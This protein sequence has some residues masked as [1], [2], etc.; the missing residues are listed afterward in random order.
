VGVARTVL[1]RV[2]K[3]LKARWGPA[4]QSDTDFIESAFREILGRNAD[5]D[6]LTHYRRVLRDGLGRTAVLLDIM[7][8]DESL[9]KLQKTKP[10]GTGSALPDIRSLRPDRYRNA[11]DRTNQ[12]TI[13]VFDASSAA[14]FDWLEDAI[15]KYGYYEQ[16]GVWTLGIDADKVIVA[17]MIASLAPRRALELG[18]AAGAVLECLDDLG[19]AAEGVEISAMARAKAS[20]RVR[21]RIHDGDLLALDLPSSFDVLFGLDVFEHLNPNRLDAYVARLAAIALDGAFVFCNIP[22]FGHDPQFGT[23]FPLYLDGWERDTAAGRPFATLHVDELGYP[24]HGH[25]TWADARWWVSCFE[26]AGLQREIEIERALHA[27]YDR[28][29]EKRAPARKAY[30]VFAKSPSSDR[31]A[32]AIERIRSTPTRAAD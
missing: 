6:G 11:I 28:Y 16:P 5:L 2:F 10:H 12:Q 30:F 24:I 22:A 26:R 21:D 18:C 15:V 29:M 31:R 9:A 8:S 14:D 27:K 7:R 1:G 17:E 25:L 20:P 4:F 32:A 23:V 19:I 13:A 3:R